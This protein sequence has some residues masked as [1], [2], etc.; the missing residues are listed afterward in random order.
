MHVQSHSPASCSISSSNMLAHLGSSS[1]SSRCLRTKCIPGLMGKGARSQLPAAWGRSGFM[2]DFAPRFG[3]H[4]SY[5]DIALVI[6]QETGGLQECTVRIE[7]DLFF[8]GLFPA[9][10]II[11]NQTFDKT[12]H[13]SFCRIKE[14]TTSEYSRPLNNHHVLGYSAPRLPSEQGSDFFSAA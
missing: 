11:Q 6:L 3:E 12:C 5:L 9:C 1:P 13:V 14:L 4:S 10:R 7:A 8:V 2:R